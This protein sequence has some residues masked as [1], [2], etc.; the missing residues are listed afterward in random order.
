MLT[1]Y[2]LADRLGKRIPEILEM[3]TE[4]FAGWV[5]YGRVLEKMKKK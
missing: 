3:T 1:V 5:A 2:A 4:E